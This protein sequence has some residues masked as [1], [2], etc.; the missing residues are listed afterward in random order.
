MNGL[1][2][3]NCTMLAGIWEIEEKPDSLAETCLTGLVRPLDKRN[4]SRC[5]LYLGDRD[6]PI[7]GDS[8]T[9]ESHAAPFVN[10]S[11][12]IKASQAKTPSSPPFSILAWSRFTVVS[13]NPEKP[14]SAKS[15]SSGTTRSSSS[16]T[17]K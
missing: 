2:R 4:A 9:Y 8:K 7:V 3:L 1:D 15:A 5:E 11:K 10:R 14:R 16:Q 12:S 6:A 17:S 13:A